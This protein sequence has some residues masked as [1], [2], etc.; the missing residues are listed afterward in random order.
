MKCTIV[1]MKEEDKP[2]SEVLF[3][4]VFKESQNFGSDPSLSAAAGEPKQELDP[5]FF[6]R[7]NWQAYSKLGWMRREAHCPKFVLK[8]TPADVTLFPELDGSWKS[9]FPRS[10]VVCPFV[11][12]RVRM[13]V[14]TLMYF[15][16]LA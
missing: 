16:R 3:A 2:T 10:I 1:D 15:H 13:V 12:R 4:A 8:L 9:I 14:Q 7:S 11:S 6:I 5:N